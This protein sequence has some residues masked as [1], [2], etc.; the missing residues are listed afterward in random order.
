M[1]TAHAPYNPRAS[2]S[3]SSPLLTCRVHEFMR[4]SPFTCTSIR[5][6]PLETRLVRSGNVFLVINSPLSVL[7]GPGEAQSFVSCSQDGY[8]SGPSSPKA[9]IDDISLNGSQGDTRRWP[10]IKTCSDLR[11]GCTSVTVNDSRQS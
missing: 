9:H 4:L 5:S 7:T 1:P 8:M 10:S 3:L 11:K 2:T 6:I